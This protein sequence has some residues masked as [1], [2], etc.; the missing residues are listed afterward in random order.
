MGIMKARSRESS[1]GGEKEK[2]RREGIRFRY[3]NAKPSRRE[4]SLPL[5][6]RKEAVDLETSKIESTFDSSMPLPLLPIR[7][8]EHRSAS[9]TKKVQKE[10]DPIRS[11]YFNVK[12][13]REKVTNINFN[14]NLAS[15]I[16]SKYL[17]NILKEKDVSKVSRMSSATQV[18]LNIN[19]QSV[20]TIHQKVRQSEDVTKKADEFSKLSLKTKLRVANLARDFTFTSIPTKDSLFRFAK[21]LYNGMS[22]VADSDLDPIETFPDDVSL[23][24]SRSS[25]H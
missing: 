5:I 4:R 23:T 16:H 9:R 19:P 11:I 18:Q 17:M 1:A 14:Q 20:Q 7:E 21:L 12:L 24:F 25:L 3:V 10:S 6:Q 15:N 8:R 2:S 22:L 13:S